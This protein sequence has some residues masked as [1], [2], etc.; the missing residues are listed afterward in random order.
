M[1]RKAPLVVGSRAYSE[2]VAAGRVIA[3]S[4]APATRVERADLDVVLRVSRGTALAAVPEVEGS[5]QERGG[6]R[7]APGR[8]RGRGAQRGVVGDA[9]GPR[10]L[11]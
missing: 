4:P 2:T 6:R 10:H 9:R 5:S 8:V 7:A 11:E 3:Q 1:P